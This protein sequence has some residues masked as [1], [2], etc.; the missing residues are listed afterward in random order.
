MM[1]IEAEWRIYA[2]IDYTISG[3][4]NGLPT[5]G[6]NPL[7]EPL[8]VY[9]QLDPKEH[10][11]IKFCLKF[12]SFHSRKCKWKGRL[13]KWWT[14]CLGLNVLNYFIFQKSILTTPF[15]KIGNTNRQRMPHIFGIT[16][17]SCIAMTTLQE[18]SMAVSKVT[19]GLWR[20]DS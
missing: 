17:I 11:S 8:K 19:V 15:R 13:Q 5:V 7:S 1:Q 16:L 4:D 12:E 6:D 2:P 18:K 14:S 20:P 9:R 10:I 3:L